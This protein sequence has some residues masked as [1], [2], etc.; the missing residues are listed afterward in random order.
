MASFELFIG[1]MTYVQILLRGNMVRHMGVTEYSLMAILQNQH[2]VQI[3][4][5][6]DYDEIK[7]PYFPPFF[8]VYNL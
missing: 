1:H 3:S 8:L 6:N 5:L 2:L 4:S 7:L